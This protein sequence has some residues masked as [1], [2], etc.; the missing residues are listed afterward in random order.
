MITGVQLPAGN[1]RLAPLPQTNP[2]WEALT[3]EY[4]LDGIAPGVVG[5]HRQLHQR[6][7]IGTFRIVSNYFLLSSRSCF[8]YFLVSSN[9]LLNLYDFNSCIFFLPT[10]IQYASLHVKPSQLTVGT[11][12]WF[13]VCASS[14]VIDTPVID[15]GPWT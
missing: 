7:G 12:T 6:Q 8:K 11:D 4:T 9:S 5:A 3:R 2:P 10:R 15:M 1:C 14:A 13:V